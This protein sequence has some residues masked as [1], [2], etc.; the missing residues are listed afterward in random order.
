M[1]RRVLRCF[2]GG[3]FLL[4]GLAAP[5]FSQ[6]PTKV[7]FEA[8]LIV[9]G[10]NAFALDLYEKLNEKDSNLFFSPYSISTALAMTY[11]GARGDTAREM[12]NVLH[13][14]PDGDQLHRG[15]GELISGLNGKSGPRQFELTIANRLWGQ[16]DYTFDP[17]FIKLTEGTYGAGL[18]EV[19][20]K[21]ATEQARQT[22]NGWVEEQTKNKIKELLKPGILKSDTRFVLTN[23]IYFKASWNVPFEKQA[24]RPGP[25]KLA[26]DKSIEDVPLMQKVMAVRYLAKDGIQVAAIPYVR[27]ELSMVVLLPTEVDGLPGLEKSLAVPGYLADL[28]DQIKGNRVKVTLPKFKVTAEFHLKEALQ[29]LGMKTAFVMGKADFTGITTREPLA[30][31]AVIHKAFVDVNEAGT[32]A[33]AATAVA[34]GGRGKNAP[35]PPPEFRADHP[36][37]YLI[38]DNNSGSILFMGRLLNPKG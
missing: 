21:E 9:K 18:K 29:A 7:S 27:Q 38:M 5:G 11:G 12:A 8:T 32:E 28:L 35:P 25:F 37:V 16:K 3:L 33:A 23:A 14:I 30:I 26:G 13:F 19:N 34:G 2:V 4:A 24:T 20:F 36:F 15:F 22:I 1:T 31:S 10:N 17:N 6:P